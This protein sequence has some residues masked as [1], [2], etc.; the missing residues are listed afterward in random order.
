MRKSFD[1]K[2]DKMRKEFMATL[3]GKI[4]T[5]DDE[6]AMDMSR[7]SGRIDVLEKTLQSLQTRLDTVGTNPNSHNK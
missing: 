4:R 5:P 3:G 2:L 7:E 1:T 6:L